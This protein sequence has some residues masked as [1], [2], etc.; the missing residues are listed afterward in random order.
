MLFARYENIG[1]R[2]LF[3][4][5]FPTSENKFSSSFG[6]K[7]SFTF[8]EAF[9]CGGRGIRT[10]GG[11]TLNSF[12]DCR[13]RPL[14]HSSFTHYRGLRPPKQ[15]SCVGGCKYKSLFPFPETNWKIFEVFP[16]SPGSLLYST[17]VANPLPW[18]SP[19]NFFFW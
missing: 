8:R 1:L 11:V 3:F 7:K 13:I 2:Q 6:N 9:V 19:G 15:R 4:I 5:P 14:C 12:Q 10:P 16:K 18:K 17:F